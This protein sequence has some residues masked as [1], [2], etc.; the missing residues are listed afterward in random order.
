MSIKY[1]KDRK[2]DQGSIKYKISSSARP[3]KIYP[4]LDFWFE[5][6]PSGNPD[7]QARFRKVVNWVSA[8]P[9]LTSANVRQKEKIL[10]ESWRKVR[11]T[12]NTD[13]VKK[14]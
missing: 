7:G 4:N 6:K 8:V 5:N 3:S 9:H 10:E 12:V 2:M 13:R 11:Q 14:D 1:D